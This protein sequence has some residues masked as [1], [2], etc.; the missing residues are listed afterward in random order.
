M[1]NVTRLHA[2]LSN[3]SAR[4]SIRKKIDGETFGVTLTRP[5]IGFTIAAFKESAEKAKTGELSLSVRG[6]ENGVTK[7]KSWKPERKDMS[8]GVEFIDAMG[9]DAD[10]SESNGEAE[11]PQKR[12]KKNGVTG[13]PEKEPE[14]V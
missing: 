6:E 13:Q 2:I 12:R 11:K 5:V 10:E 4:S 9:D 3:P 7:S 8:Q 1:A 14:T